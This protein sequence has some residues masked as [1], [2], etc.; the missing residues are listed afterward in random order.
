MEITICQEHRSHQQRFHPQNA[1]RESG[2]FKLF[3]AVALWAGLGIPMPV[4]IWIKD[5]LNIHMDNFTSLCQCQDKINIHKHKFWRPHL[6]INLQ[7]K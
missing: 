4:H 6:C 2:K 5:T 3:K 7:I 1:R